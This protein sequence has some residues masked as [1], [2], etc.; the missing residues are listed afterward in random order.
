MPR[1][2]PASPPHH[3][4]AR[5]TS[6]H[7]GVDRNNNTKNRTGNR[8]QPIDSCLPDRRTHRLKADTRPS[9]YQPGGYSSSTNQTGS[10]SAGGGRDRGTS[11][12]NL[13]DSL[14]EDSANKNS[15]SCECCALESSS[16]TSAN[17][18]RHRQVIFAQVS[19]THAKEPLVSKGLL[20]FYLISC[21]NGFESECKPWKFRCIIMSAV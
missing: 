15:Y 21:S 17:S 8:Q 7:A 19:K 14:T 20:L 18:A 5:Q 13:G 3:T 9:M 2:F 4:H 1:H 12:S 11:S 6:G 16:G 10:S